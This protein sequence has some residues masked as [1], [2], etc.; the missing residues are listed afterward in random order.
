MASA[1]MTDAL[2][3]SWTTEQHAR[4]ISNAAG[5]P[6]W[7]LEDRLDGIRRA[8]GL[9]LEANQLFVSYVDLRAAKLTD[10]DPYRESGDAA[11]V[12]AEVPGGAAGLLEI[13]EDRV[14]G[15]ALSPAA[16]EAGVIVDSFAN[17]LRADPKLLERFLPGAP[18]LPETDRIGQLARGLWTVGAL[19][20]VPAGVRVDAP[21][22]VRWDVGAASRGVV[23][24]TL[25]VLEDGAHASVL[26]E[27]ASSM[28]A[29]DGGQSLWWGTLE[30]RLAPGATLD[31]AGLQEFGPQ[32]VMLV[33]R[34][35]T[36]ERDA[37]LR[38]ALASVG[39]LVQKSRIDNVL[40]GRGATVHQAEIAFGSGQQLFDLTSYTRHIAED[41]T[42][43]LLSKG[44]FLDRARGYFKG[45]IEIKRSA[46]GTDSF[47][48]EFAMLLA[49]RA[50][51][52]AIPSL[53]ID[54]PDVRRASHA[55]SVAPIDET[56]LFYLQS[57]GLDLDTARRFIV[58]GF[59][60]P[61]V[62]RIPL[63]DAQDRLRASLDRKWAPAAITRAA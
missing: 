52:V 12:S 32:T 51:S 56:Q 33:N 61:V 50:R 28:L 16:R 35:A 34:H 25:V 19:I 60:E 11:D 53:E 59:L 36:L 31:V 7:L 26:E 17:V 62:A 8:E 13:R 54:Q 9:P 58:L 41:T 40:Q 23:S 15:R 49:K 4:T 22:V 20:Y 63:P 3:L 10:V 21:I 38:W 46:R 55:S 29:A 47:L 5:E 14:V 39:G 57:R 27:Q 24:R 30:V 37:S 43:D 1:A 2:T 45:L 48:G 42:G 18:S 6:G 44:V